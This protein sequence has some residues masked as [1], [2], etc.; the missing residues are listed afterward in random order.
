MTGVDAENPGSSGGGI[1]ARDDLG[2]S[3]SPA[4]STAGD[5]SASDSASI[6]KQVIKNVA[7]DVA[8]EEFRPRFRDIYKQFVRQES[9]F[10]DRVSR[11]EEQLDDSEISSEKHQKEVANIV[12]ARI[13]SSLTLTGVGLSVV[14]TLLSIIFT[15]P[16]LFVA[17]L[18]AAMF[19]IYSYKNS[20][21]YS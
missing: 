16:L 9:R 14:C 21:Q 1:T 3:Y 13:N 20:P 17:S 15:S 12:T 7:E 8:E 10:E 18:I 2:Q 5:V 4:E 6:E 11:I 19:L